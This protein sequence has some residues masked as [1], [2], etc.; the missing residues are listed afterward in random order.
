MVSSSINVSED[1][2]GFLIGPKGQNKKLIERTGGVKLII[3]ECMVTVTGEDGFKVMKATEVIRA[4]GEGLP[5]KKAFELFREDYQ[6]VIYDIEDAV[7]NKAALERQ[8]GRIIGEKGKTKKYFE[9]MLNLKI[10]ISE[11][12]VIAVGPSDK[13][14]IFRDA[15]ERLVHG[16][17]HSG[18]YRYVETRLLHIRPQKAEIEAEIR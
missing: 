7:V 6:L 2:L 11:S 1:H 13:L 3:D 9:R 5:L 14:R 17:P 4:L 10:H 8:K 15:L 18:V 12:K 16:A